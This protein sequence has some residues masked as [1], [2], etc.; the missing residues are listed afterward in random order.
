MRRNFFLDVDSQLRTVEHTLTYLE[1]AL[2]GVPCHR[3][4]IAHYEQ[5]LRDPRS[6]VGPLSSFLELD[7]SASAELSRRLSRNGKF[8]SRKEHKLT[9]YP[10]CQKA[11]LSDNVKV[12][13]QLITN[14]LDRFF[15][16]R[17]FMWPTFAANGFDFV[18][19]FS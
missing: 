7:K 19:E 10:E 6:F 13:S 2:R 4:F 18:P 16:E 11:G 17:N 8:P 5:V 1:S 14:L 3:I 12:C 9:Q 15:H